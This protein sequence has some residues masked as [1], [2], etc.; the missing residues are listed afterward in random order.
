MQLS[1]FPSTHNNQQR[2]T[3]T[4]SKKR[5]VSQMSYE[6][7]QVFTLHVR[8]TP[9]KLS[10]RQ[11]EHDSPRTNFFYKCFIMQSRN[12]R[13]VEAFNPVIF[14]VVYDYLC[15]DTIFPLPSVLAGTKTREVVFITLRDYAIALG[16]NGL[17]EALS[18][19]E[20]KL[21]PLN[22]HCKSVLKSFALQCITK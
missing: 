6:S 8:G 20:C 7:E 10:A 16:L 13:Y 1:E 17:L 21:D 9:F 14:Q 3:K 5:F 18:A 4:P 2:R 11:I 19:E 12:A 15:G 22:K